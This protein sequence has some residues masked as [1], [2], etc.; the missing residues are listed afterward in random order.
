MVRPSAHIT[1]YPAEKVGRLKRDLLVS[2][3]YRVTRKVETFECVAPKGT[4]CKLIVGHWYIAEL[5]WLEP[6]LGTP[7]GQERTHVVYHGARAHGI[8]IDGAEVAQ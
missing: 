7:P 8:E 2:V 4:A 6:L 5:N 3:P 1:D